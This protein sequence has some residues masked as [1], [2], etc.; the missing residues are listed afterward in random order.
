[1]SPRAASARRR[2]VRR[3]HRLRNRRHG[4][5][6]HQG[7]GRRRSD[8]WFELGKMFGLVASVTG[9]ILGQAEL[10]GEPYRHWLTITCIAA[11]GGFGYLLGPQ[12][13]KT[14]LGKITKGS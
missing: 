1:M 7:Y 5:R 11:T 4:Q 8:I 3:Q 2:L 6:R 12:S 9:A 13:L 10:V 14:L